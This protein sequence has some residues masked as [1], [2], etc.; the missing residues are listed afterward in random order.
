MKLKYTEDAALRA[1]KNHLATMAL[2]EGIA[3]DYDSAEESEEDTAVEHAP[4]QE[5]QTPPPPLPPKPG[6]VRSE[7]PL[8]DGIARLEFPAKLSREMLEDFE[9]WLQLILRQAKRAEQ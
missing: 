2:V 8:G 3:G 9:A 1:A 5:R 6:M 4:K 7:F